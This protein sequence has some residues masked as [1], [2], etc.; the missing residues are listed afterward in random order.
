MWLRNIALTA[1]NRLRNDSHLLHTL[2]LD[3]GFHNSH[4]PG[5]MIERVDGDVALLGNFFSRFVVNLLGNAVLLIGVLVVLTA[6]DWRVGL[7]VGICSLLGIV[8]MNS[9]RNFAVP[10]FRRR[11]RPAPISSATWRSGW[12]GLRNIPP[13]GAMSM[14]CAVYT[15]GGARSWRNS[16]SGHIRQ[17][18]WNA[19]FVF[20]TFA[21]RP[22]W[23]SAA[24]C[25]CSTQSR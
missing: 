8:L 6:I 18:R 12:P 9:L 25:S 21:L 5:E 20:L 14:R 23:A 13:S 24:T 4:T 11:G 15:P 7:A 22:P 10:Q 17:H 2:H 1:T 3:P 16:A 19:T